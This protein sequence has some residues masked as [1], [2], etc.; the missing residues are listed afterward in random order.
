MIIIL[1]VCLFTLIAA[2]FYAVYKWKIDDEN[3]QKNQYIKHFQYGLELNYFDSSDVKKIQFY[4]DLLKSNKQ[5]TYDLQSIEK[6]INK[7]SQWRNNPSI[8]NKWCEICERHYSKLN[9]LIMQC[10]NVDI[11]AYY[12]KLKFYWQYYDKNRVNI[13]SIFE[14][15]RQNLIEYI[16]WET[17]YNNIKD[18][19]NKKTDENLIINQMFHIQLKE[20]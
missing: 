12:E 13:T 9:K 8:K 6:I 1:F 14:T 10:S 5:T 20:I 11:D 18:C 17:H 3:F 7:Y 19:I 15:F 2:I 4:L 16:D